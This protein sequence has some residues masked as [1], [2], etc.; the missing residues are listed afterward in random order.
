MSQAPLP[1]TAAIS[2]IFG[3]ALPIGATLCTLCSETREIGFLIG[4]T[5]EFITVLMTDSQLAAILQ[6][7]LDEDLVTRLD[8]KITPGAEH[9]H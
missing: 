4:A 7:G 2:A 9:Y 1:V 8:T 6:I 5:G 3:D